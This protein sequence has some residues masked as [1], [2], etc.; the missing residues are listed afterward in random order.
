MTNLAMPQRAGLERH[1][2][3]YPPT[4]PEKRNG[5]CMA[6]VDGTIPEGSLGGEDGRLHVRGAC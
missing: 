6:H 1:L 3:A 4:S 5:G 2:Q